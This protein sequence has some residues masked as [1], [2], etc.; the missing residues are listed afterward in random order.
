MYEHPGNI[1]HG[2]GAALEGVF[3]LAHHQKSEAIPFKDIFAGNIFCGYFIPVKP[4]RF[5]FFP[6]WRKPFQQGQEWFCLR[7]V[8]TEQA[9]QTGI[10]FIAVQ[11]QDAVAGSAQGVRQQGDHSALPNA[12]FT[13]NGYLL[14]ED[15]SLRMSSQIP[16]YFS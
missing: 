7:A 6:I 9:L 16:P 14:A 11:N 12:A 15:L 13:S 3:Y 5:W 2:T 10:R 1:R 4:F 8:K